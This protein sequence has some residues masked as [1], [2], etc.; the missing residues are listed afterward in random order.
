MIQPLADRDRPVSWP[1][2]FGYIRVVGQ[3]KLGKLE[4]WA[5]C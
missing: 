4:Y 5:Q 1:Y 3:H 2:V